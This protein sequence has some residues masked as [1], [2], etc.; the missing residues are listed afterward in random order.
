[1]KLKILILFIIILIQ[2]CSKNFVLINENKIYVEIA[3]TPSERSTGLMYRENL[4]NDCGMLFIF[5]NEETHSFWMKNTLIPLDMI[6]IS[7]DKKI[8]DTVQAEPCKE[9]PCQI[10][11]PQEKSKYVLEVNKEYSKSRN[12]NIGDSVKINLKSLS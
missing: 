8:V 10:Y 2:G 5:D 1:M 3:D 9:D 4:C 7:E 12:I 11:K 6:F